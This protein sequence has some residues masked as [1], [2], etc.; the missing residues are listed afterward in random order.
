MTD[1]ASILRDLLAQSASTTERPVSEPTPRASI[2]PAPA[3]LRV[4]SER[5]GR[6]S[7]GPATQ[8]P[9]PRI[10]A[11]RLARAIAV[12]SGKGGVG[13]S[14]LALNLSIELARLGRRVA[15]FDADLGCANADVLCGLPVKA[16]LAD[17]VHG[18]RRLSE[19]MVR[20]PG[21]RGRGG[22]GL[23]PGASGVTEVAT[24]HATQRQLL[25]EQLVALEKVVD[26]VLIDVGAGIAADAVGFASA[27]DSV[28]LTCTPEPTAMTDAY[29]AAKA[30]LARRP[31]LDLSLVV[32]MAGSPEE[33]LAVHE[34]MDAV[35]RRHL[36]RTIPL[37]GV[38]P[39]DFSVVGAVKRRKPL[40]LVAP[41]ARATV[42]IRTIAGSLLEDRPR[43][44][45]SEPRRG[46]LAGLLRTFARD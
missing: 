31:D 23:V 15:L 9:G 24:L 28:L 37:A 44:E 2:G 8:R 4:D 20:V 13:K 22:V 41:D 3:D 30:I 40:S 12:A 18:R 29:A 6:V 7:F 5:R 35:A 38:V 33:G 16:T 1:Q 26:L 39:F 27:A 36:G 25:V 17:V 32:N 21:I 42:A 19:I 11:P 45:R 43:G 46:F 10:E 14:N 34:R